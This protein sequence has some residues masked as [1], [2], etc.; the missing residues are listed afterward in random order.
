[1]IA[2]DAA[3]EH[4]DANTLARHAAYAESRV[5]RSGHSVGSEI[6]STASAVRLQAGS[7]S[8]S[9]SCATTA[10]MRRS[11]DSARAAFAEA[12]QPTGAD[13]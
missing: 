4:A 3:V 1:M 10:A 13:C 12:N 2:L 5:T 11:Y 8:R 6:R 7:S 9:D